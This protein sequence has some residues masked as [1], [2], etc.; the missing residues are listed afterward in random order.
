MRRFSG[1]RQIKPSKSVDVDFGLEMIHWKHWSILQ[2]P[3]ASMSLEEVWV[4]RN[5]LPNHQ[6]IHPLPLRVYMWQNV[7]VVWWSQFWVTG[8]CFCRFFPTT[9]GPS[10]S[11]PS[12]K[13]NCGLLQTDSSTVHSVHGFLMEEPQAF[14]RT[15]TPTT[16]C[17]TNPFSKLGEGNEIPETSM[18][19]TVPLCS[20][21]VYWKNIQCGLK[22]SAML[23]VASA[24]RNLQMLIFVE[25]PSR[26]LFYRGILVHGMGG[27][28]ADWQTWVELLSQRFPD[29]ILWPL[30]KL[31]A[32]SSFLGR[33]L[34]DLSKMAAAEI[35]EVVRNTQS[36]SLPGQWSAVVGGFLW[37]VARVVALELTAIETT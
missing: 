16:I 9:W 26:I 22:K 15:I 24:Q 4:D 18:K 5:I 27:S 35:S 31:K 30:Q 23:Q 6:P 7:W 33:D 13:I 25:F 12:P 37:D 29:W 20:S 21:E 11:I 2:H 8:I 36:S 19:G 17:G 3:C 10:S 14:A 34:R 28:E 32:A 1:R